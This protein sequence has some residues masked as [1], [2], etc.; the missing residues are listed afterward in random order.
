MKPGCRRREPKQSQV[1]ERRFA[2][3]IAGMFQDLPYLDAPRSP[4]R[5]NVYCANQY[6]DL[7]RSGSFVDTM[8]G[9]EHPHIGNQHTATERTSIGTEVRTVN[10]GNLPLVVTKLRYCSADDLLFKQLYPVAILQVLIAQRFR[11]S[12]LW[13]VGPQERAWAHE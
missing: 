13:R 9:S 4:V 6:T 10:Q 7:S 12:D 3:K 11:T 1:M 2:G 8:G 5:A